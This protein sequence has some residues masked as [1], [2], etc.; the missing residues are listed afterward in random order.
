MERRGTN[1]PVAAHAEDWIRAGDWV[2]EQLRRSL[3]VLAAEAQ[4][5][6]DFYPPNSDIMG[7]LATDYLHFAETIFTYWKL[8]PNQALQLKALADFFHALDRPEEEKFWTVQALY[9]DP[10]WN[11]VRRLAK[12]ALSSLEWPMKEREDQI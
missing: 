1:D 7:E 8:S 10:R 9:D 11:E 4:R 3:Q 2:A 6:V 5:Q 12:H